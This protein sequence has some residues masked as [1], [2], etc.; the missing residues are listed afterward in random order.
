MNEPR[1]IRYFKN[2]EK[3]EIAKEVLVQEGF[4]AYVTEDKFYDIALKELGMISRFRLYVDRK[5]IKSIAKVLEK[6]LMKVKE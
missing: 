5:D 4:E 1:C 2:K 6:K 3:A